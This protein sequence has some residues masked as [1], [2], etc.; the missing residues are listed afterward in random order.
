MHVCTGNYEKRH[1]VTEMNAQAHKQ[2]SVTCHCL[3]IAMHSRRC[4]YVYMSGKYSR[5]DAKRF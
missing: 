2:A 4:K 3:S 1:H 5:R